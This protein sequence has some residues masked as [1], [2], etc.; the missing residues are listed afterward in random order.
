MSEKKV[1]ILTTIFEMATG[2]TL[3]RVVSEPQPKPKK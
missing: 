3:P 1:N 2:V